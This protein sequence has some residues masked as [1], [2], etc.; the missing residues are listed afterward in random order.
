[1]VVA[2][3]GHVNFHILA[4]FFKQKY[5]PTN[6]NNR[7]ESV[8]GKSVLCIYLTLTS[9]CITKETIQMLAHMI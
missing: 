7:T 6:L 1:M 8:S 9:H 5:T 2:Q 4:I 3:I